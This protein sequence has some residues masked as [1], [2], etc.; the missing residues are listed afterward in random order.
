VTTHDLLAELV[1]SRGELP[2]AIFQ[3]SRGVH[4][5]ERNL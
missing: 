5:T 3:C 1:E 4:V 2:N